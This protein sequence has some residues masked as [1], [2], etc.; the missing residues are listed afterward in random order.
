M[1]HDQQQTRKRNETA[2]NENYK[3]THESR[4]QRGTSD[5]EQYS[6]ENFEREEKERVVICLR[7]WERAFRAARVSARTKWQRCRSTRRFWVRLICVSRCP[8]RLVLALAWPGLF[9][10]IARSFVHLKEDEKRVY[11]W[12]MDG[13]NTTNTNQRLREHYLQLRVLRRVT[14]KKYAR[15]ARNGPTQYA[16]FTTTH[17][18]TIK[19]Y[20]Y[21]ATKDTTA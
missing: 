1:Q 11:V 20:L 5:R 3:Q 21:M 8:L 14:F 16:T 7:L 18:T 19:K 13:R 6:E 12:N 15:C 17:Y 4:E 10:R 9:R 2:T